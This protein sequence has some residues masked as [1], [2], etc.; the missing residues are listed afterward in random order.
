MSRAETMENF[1][2]T[3]I[4]AITA[5]KMSRGRS[6]AE[7]VDQMLA[8]GIRFLQYREKEKSAREMYEECRVLRQ[9]T[10]SA[11]AAFIIDDF[12]DLALAVDADGVHIGQTDLPPAAVRRLVGPAKVIG[13]STHNLEQLQAAN[14][15]GNLIDYIGVGP[16]F[17]TATK[18][19]AAVGLDYVRQ[20]AHSSLLPY[21]AIGGIKEHNIGAVAEAGADTV[22]VVS[23]IVG[24]VDIDASIATLRRCFRAGN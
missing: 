13:L 19:T 9:M 11:G 14:A 20:A 12:V 6:N 18:A 23:G 21:V 7:V 15:M 17:P 8:A 5:E 3:E 22:A 2:N 10:R 24:A 16:V 4:Y 1:K